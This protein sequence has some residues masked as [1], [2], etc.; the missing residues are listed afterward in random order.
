MSGVSGA[1]RSKF[2]LDYHFS[3]VNESARPY[4]V[5]GTHRHTPEIEQSLS[6]QTK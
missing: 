5:G 4:G 1:G 6:W 2:S 3:E